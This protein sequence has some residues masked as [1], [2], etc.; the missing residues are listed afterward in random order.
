MGLRRTARGH[1]WQVIPAAGSSLD[2]PTG[3]G[4]PHPGA[5]AGPPI[6]W[7]GLRRVLVVRQ[8]NLGD[9]L[10]TGPAL[11]ALRR[12]APSAALHLLAAPA[13]AAAADLLPEVDA[14]L[15]HSPTWQL[16][17]PAPAPDPAAE[18]ALVQRLR[19]GAYDAAVVL[20]SFSQS[21]WPA[22][23]ACLLAGIP[24]RVGLSKEF[25]GALLTH[26]VPS[27]PD[28]L[29]QVDRALYLLARLGVPDDGTALR[30]VV[31]AVMAAHP[32]SA[33][34]TSARSNPTPPYAV[35]LPGASCSSRRW[36]TAGFSQLV[37]E[38]SAAGLQVRVAGPSAEADLVAKV[39]AGTTGLPVLDLDVVGLARLVLG[40]EV[41]VCNNS[42]GMHLADALGTPLVVAFAGTELEEQY[43]PRSTRAVV[44]R[45]PTLCSPCRLFTCP[46]AHECLDLDPAE[47]AAAALSLLR[48]RAA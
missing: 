13:G 16:A 30:A 9:V 41:V 31:P 3:P 15:V 27:P 24:L 26:W 21:P 1:F 19:D 36:S 12:A 6:D 33:V 45:R 22:A 28:E 40:A 5:L 39:C 43:A 10:A 23:Y 46:Y 8:D 34:P 42:G 38:L 7:A 4:G 47:V 14:V 18:L 17:G 35:V 32:S 37:R 11:R 20:T 2:A 44:L 48:E 25:G 29:H